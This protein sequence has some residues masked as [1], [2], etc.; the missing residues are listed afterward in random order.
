MK[1][2]YGGLK[3]FSVS[4][5]V[6]RFYRFPRSHLTNTINAETAAGG[7]EQTVSQRR[8]G[9]TET[10]R[11]GT[12]DARNAGGDEPKAVENARPALGSLAFFNGL[13][14][15]AGRPF[16]PASARVPVFSG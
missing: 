11:N 10:K 13:R 6:E 15:I 12:R 16:R 5:V 9:E 14:L 1:K 8:N 2:F 3:L 4:T 7:A